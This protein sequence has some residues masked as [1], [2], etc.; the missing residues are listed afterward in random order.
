M[1]AR[2]DIED[3]WEQL[4]WALGTAEQF[5]LS[6]AS[7]DEGRAAAILQLRAILT[8]LEQTT[9][10][11]PATPL[12]ILLASLQDLENGSVPPMLRPKTVKHRPRGDVVLRTV[13]VM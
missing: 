11:C 10:Y 1:H 6:N 8:F 5:C 2:S 4:P 12:W 9:A 7:D 3:Q 13:K